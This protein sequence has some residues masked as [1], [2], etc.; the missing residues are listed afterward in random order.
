M[1]KN[2]L[3]YGANGYTGELITRFAVERGMRPIIAG[4]NAAAIR[5]LAAKHGLDHRTFSLDERDKLD[6][7]MGD[8]EMVL[9]CAGPFSFTSR[10]MVGACLRNRKHYTDITGEI[11]VFEECADKNDRAFEAGVMLMPGVGFDV[12]P[13]DCLALHLKER[14]PSANRL[15]L[16][17][18]SS[19]GL[20]RGTATTM[21]ENI[22]RGG[23]VR[24]GGR[25]VPVPAGWKTVH[26]DLGAGTVAVTTLPWGDVATAWY[27]TGIPDIQVYTR[28][29]AAMR[30]GLTASRYLGPILSSAPV[31]RLLKQRIR[32][33]A[34]GPDAAARARGVSKI[35][36][37][38]IDVTGRTA[39]ARIQGPEGYGMTALTAV[40]A[41]ERVLAG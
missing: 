40:A 32:S 24:R 22:S 41:A 17:F 2:F 3:I 12:V 13:S 14:L 9:H 20:S 37:G 4:R 27:S 34:P 1:T 33:G 15:L 26:V 35:Y 38:V 36:W 39:N 31:Q 21:V 8:V 7:A 19:G 18:Q 5:E 28:T 6:A 23:A 25:I 30:F 29:T 16:A 10:P 11:S